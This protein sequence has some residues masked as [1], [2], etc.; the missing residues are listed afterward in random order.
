MQ[1]NFIG[2]V[3]R[4]QWTR[5]SSK[6]YSRST[7][8]RLFGSWN[9]AVAEAG[10]APNTNI[11]TPIKQCLV[12]GKDTKRQYCSVAC[13]NRDKPRRV[14]KTKCYSCSALIRSGYKYCTKCFDKARISLANKTKGELQ[15]GKKNNANC[16]SAINHHAR[17]L[18][19]SR[20]KPCTACGYKKHVQ[21]CHVKAIRAFPDSA[22]ISEINDFNNIILLCPNCHWEFDHP[23]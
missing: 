4:E 12:C 23:N 2:S 1:N 6:P 19:W 15:Y 21:V 7:V 18:Y 17:Y 8:V 3:S 22:L 20:G 10:L 11:V 14:R 9:Q 13:S 5:H 16:Y